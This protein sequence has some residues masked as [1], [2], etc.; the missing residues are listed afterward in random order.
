MRTRDYDARP[1][2]ARRR[3]RERAAKSGLAKETFSERIPQRERA[4]ETRKKKFVKKK[5]C[6][7]RQCLLSKHRVSGML[8]VEDAIPGGESG[9][10]DMQIALYS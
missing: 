8:T 3:S 6:F 4:F 1:L 5:A 7:F 9:T 10:P 2:L